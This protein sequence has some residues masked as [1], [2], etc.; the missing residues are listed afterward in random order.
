MLLPEYGIHPL[1]KCPIRSPY[2]MLVNTNDMTVLITGE[3]PSWLS[4]GHDCQPLQLNDLFLPTESPNHYMTV[5][6]NRL[7]YICSHPV[8]STYHMLLLATDVTDLNTG[9]HMCLRVTEYGVIEAYSMEQSLSQD[10]AMN[11]ILL[12]RPIMSFVHED[13]IGLLCNALSNLSS[14]RVRW[15]VNPSTAYWDEE[16]AN[17]YYA[18][19][20]IYI[21]RPHDWL[22]CMVELPDPSL[23]WSILNLA[24]HPTTA[25]G[26]L[27]MV[28]MRLMES[29]LYHAMGM[30][31]RA[32]AKFSTMAILSLTKE[33]QS[34]AKYTTHL[35][36]SLRHQET[37]PSI[38]YVLSLLA[39]L[40]ILHSPSQ[41][42]ELVEDALDAIANMVVVASESD[43]TPQYIV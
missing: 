36:T 22:I 10:L 12:N 7:L 11:E 26:L 4:V 35:K 13:D 19:A 2:L 30:T 9:K 6:S 25:S 28:Q 1:E 15:Q 16:H 17:I 8:S 5:G 33:N 43:P 39:R 32:F 23:D 31:I 24:T 41:P 3:Q 40:R 14:C 18:W 20:N 27:H 29:N 38:R 42:R 21:Q 34:L 37:R